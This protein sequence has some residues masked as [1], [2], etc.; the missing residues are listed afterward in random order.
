MEKLKLSD[1]LRLKPYAMPL[2]ASQATFWNTKQIKSQGFSR[3][4]YKA[5]SSWKSKLAKSLASVPTKDADIFRP[6]HAF[7]THPRHPHPII[8]VWP[9]EQPNLV[10][11]NLL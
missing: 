4:P 10:R 5:T 11:R 9:P 7:A 1:Y 8:S 2:T 6:D 3:I